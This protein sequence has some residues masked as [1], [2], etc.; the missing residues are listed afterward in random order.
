ML[1][2]ISINFTRPW[3]LLLLILFLGFTIIPYFT[4]SKKY[5]KTRNRLTSMAL[6][7]LVSVFVIFMLSGFTLIIGKPNTNNEIILLVDVSATETQSANKRDDFVETVI[8]QCKFDNFKIGVVTF[9]YDQEYAV[10]LT[11]DYKNIYSKYKNATLPDVSATNIASALTYA[12]SLFTN[13]G[14]KIV[15]ITDAKETDDNAKSVIRAIAASGTT[16][17]AAY[18]D[19]SFEGEDDYQITNVNLP[20]YHINV[21]DECTIMVDVYSQF[22]SNVSLNLYDNGVKSPLEEEVQVKPGHQTIAFKHSFKDEGLH[23]LSFSLN[24]N[25]DLLEENNQ[26]TTYFYLEQYNK[27]LIIEQEDGQSETLKTL[28]TEGE[29]YVVDVMSVYDDT[30]PKTALDLC[31]YDEVILNNIANADLP[32]GFDS[33]LHDYVYTY[34]GGLLTTGGS[35][36]DGTAHAYD[37]LDL[38]NTVLQQMLPVQAINYTPPVGVI[39]IID[40]SGSMGGADDSGASW[41]DWATSGAISCLNALTERDYMGIMTLDSDYGIILEPTPVTQK[42]KILSAINSVNEA[43]GS[44]VFPGAI[45]RAGQALR[46]LKQVDKK[47]IIIVSDGQVPSNEMEQYESYAKNYYETSEITISVIGVNMNVTSDQR[48]LLEDN[49]TFEDIESLGYGTAF[50]KML[51]LSKMTHG[52][53]HPIDE[54]NRSQIVTEMRD[55][56]SAKEIKEIEYETY[57]PIMANPTSALFNKVERLQD[58][59]HSNCLT[60]TLDGYYGVKVRASATT[61]LV[62]NYNIPL[63]SQWKFGKGTVGSLM[64]DV[65]GE[66]SNDFMQDSNGKQLLFNIINSVSPVENIRINDVR[67]SLYEDNY[68]NTLS[69]Y[70]SMNEGDYIEGTISYIDKSGNEVVTSLNSLPVDATNQALRELPTYVLTNLG[71]ENAYTRCKF[72][73]KTPGAYTIEVKKYNKDG[74]LIGSNKTYKSFAFSEEYELI[75]DTEIDYEKKAASLAASGNGKLIEDLE[76]PHEIV[77]S[78][79]TTLYKI[80]DLRILFAI[81][82]IACFLLDIAVRKFKFKWPHE[83][84]KKWIDG[85]KW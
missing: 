25:A 64:F 8:N 77:D 45:E 65:Y 3:Y 43:T 78:F 23:E 49:V 71:L 50:L 80:Y 32:E 11:R 33:E 53:L 68:S 27:I 1:G 24:G 54:S 56:V 30:L 69:I 21:N 85:K 46:G 16:I 9:G 39:V 37:R 14:G 15:L 34:G 18:I 29:D 7:A 58:E 44:T 63:F 67:L 31:A 13:E 57:Y 20:D 82:A 12:K 47:H 2:S 66:F 19:S 52:R 72:V 61:D 22:D 60:V 51:R 28:M 81:L 26:Y 41:L 35:N 38:Y 83:I 4:L 76:D 79:K 62:G 73:V 59:E 42:N 40:R 10:E 74:E 17:D 75:Q 55:D 6:H 84:V 5:R 36:V 48:A 70:T